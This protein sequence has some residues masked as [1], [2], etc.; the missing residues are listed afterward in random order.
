MMN[1]RQIQAQ[2]NNAYVANMVGRMSVHIHIQVDI[3][4]NERA[5]HLYN[6]PMM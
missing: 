6:V 2:I 5:K 3:N 1:E 4:V